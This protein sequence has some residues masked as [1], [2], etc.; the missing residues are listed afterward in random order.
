MHVCNEKSRSPCALANG[1][2]ILGDRWSLL[3][4]RDLMFTN[5]CEF[6]HFV[7]SGEGISTNILSD[8]LER[9]QAAGVI[10]KE[11]H[12]S[13]GKK[14]VYSLTDSGLGL[15][16]TLIEFMLWAEREI[17]QAALPRRLLAMI[18]DDRAALMQRISNRETII[19]L[20]L[21][22]EK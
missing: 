4:I 13:H 3:I 21:T 20:D 7:Q 11:P 12:P 6:G 22:A 8:R 5:R 10:A 16:P 1:L 14:F 19:E 15:A 9:L 18:H 2:D 17:P